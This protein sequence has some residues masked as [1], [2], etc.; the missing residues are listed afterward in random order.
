MFDDL[1]PEPFDA[2]GRDEGSMSNDEIRRMLELQLAKI[3]GEASAARLEARAAEIELMIQRLR[4][5]QPTGDASVPAAAPA[6]I[7]RI[8]SPDL[9]VSTP[10][11]FESWNAVR[12]ARGQSIASA[13]S[14][15]AGS[16]QSDSPIVPAASDVVT[17][18]VLPSPPR[19]K[20]E[21]NRQP[22][23][24]SPIVRYDAGSAS[25]RRP[26]FLASDQD[27]VETNVDDQPAE[28]PFVVDAESRP[29]LGASLD[30]SPVLIEE[31][32]D[33]AREDETQR[34]RP[35]AFLVSAVVHVV[36]LILLAG[37]GFSTHVPKDQVALSASAAS[38]NEE[39]VE[40]FEIKTSESMPEVEVTEPVPSETEYELSPIG[41]L[42][43]TKFSPNA[44]AAPPTA[45]AAVMSSSSTSAASAMS[46]KSVSNKKMEFCGVEGGGN[47][48]VYLVDSS[49][50]MG[51]GFES[52]RAAL[53][54]SIDLLTPEQR[55]Y[56]VFFDANPDYMRLSNANQDEPRSVFATAENKAALRRWAMRI[57]EDR[58]KAPYD[59]LRFALKLRPD[60]IFLL[61]D[62]EFPQGIE[63]LLKEENKV[64]NLF[65]ESNPISIVHTIAYY[66]EVGESR[67]Q[68]IA[69]QNQGQYRYVPKP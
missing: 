40:T 55:F 22:E 54:A 50:S 66:S 11:R 46:M 41:E 59:P 69:K 24:S 6:S 25:V 44:P 34:R 38:A 32:D 16:L 39:S 30:A 5:N 64:T 15:S 3:R 58:G 17:P 37:I 26:R 36:V 14:H 43:A 47:H 7:R 20:R 57:T 8:D 29:A 49:G 60:V 28:L 4:Q 65:G 35:A 27:E 21:P 12:A 53:L 63:D 31:D 2:R 23:S 18:P 1:S 61:S 51:D 68:R 62:G 10:R 42:A 19:D 67:M 52:A 56:V 45:M 48:F 33:D 9:Q 13:M